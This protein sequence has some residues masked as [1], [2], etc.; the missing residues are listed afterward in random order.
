MFKKILC[1]IMTGALA[2]CAGACSKNTIQSSE[3]TKDITAQKQESVE[4]GDDFRS[5][6]MEFAFELYKNSDSEDKN[7][8]LSPLSVMLVLG[9]TANG[10]GGD[11]LAQF[12]DILGGG[13]SA[14]ELSEF[15]RSYVDSLQ[16]TDKTKVSIA[17]SIWIKDMEGLRARPAF[18]QKSVD[19]YDATVYQADFD[20]KTIDDI[21]QWV[22]DKTDG[23]IDG[24]IEELPPE[25]LMVLINAI[26][27]D[28]EWQSI[29]NKDDVR[30]TDFTSY[31]GNKQVVEGMYGSEN[32][33]L[34]D[35]NTTGFIKKYKD[36]YSFV[37]LLPDEDVSIEEYVNS[38]TGEK[39]ANLIDNRKSNLTYTMI[40]KFKY[41]YTI[42]LNEPLYNMGFE[43]MFDPSA[44]DFSE[45]AEFD[46][47]NIY[48]GSVLHKTFIE[49]GEKGT[50]AAA[51]TAEILAGNAMMP[52]DTKQV[53]LDRP[54]VY[55][56]MDDETNLPIFIGT[57][58]ELD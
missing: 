37:A 27:F 50:R 35:E 56:I 46:Y 31:T 33:Y 22:D 3:L 32:E 53:Y 13:M 57:V 8:L 45:L 18:L 11:T 39:F 1:L 12:E 47:G 43:Q 25:A 36:G 30:D 52:S 54:F 5:K 29:Y 21:N 58:L 9:M 23:M 55:V 40:P 6:S 20:S 7:T 19:Y 15:Y 10:A 49:M 51:V 48:V 24:I 41:E 42:K 38:L 17:N 34:E 44:A 4:I 2:L 14:Q 26:S 28:A 16:S